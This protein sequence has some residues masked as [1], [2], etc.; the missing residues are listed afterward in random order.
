MSRAA[1]LARLGRR[2][3]HRELNQGP[4]PDGQGQQHQNLLRCDFL[5][6]KRV[7]ELDYVRCRAW[8]GG[9]TLLYTKNI[10]DRI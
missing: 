10:K 2:Q 5:V 9:S 8:L 1:R 7:E 3:D 6:F 4:G